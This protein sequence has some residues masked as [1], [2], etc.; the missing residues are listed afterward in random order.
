MEGLIDNICDLGLKIL[1]ISKSDSGGAGNAAYRLHKAMI[2]LG[3]DSKM[4]CLQKSRNGISSLVK[5]SDSILKKTLRSTRLPFNKY[6]K[7]NSLLKKRGGQYES[8]SFIESDYQVHKHQLIKEADV[9]NLHFINGFINYNSFFMKVQKPIIWTLH[10]MNP[11][12]GGFHYQEDLNRNQENLGDVE[13]HL[14][15]EKIA[16][17]KQCNELSIVSLNKWMF[18]LARN[19]EHFHDRPNLI[20]SNTLDF[21]TFNIYDKF[22]QRK[23]FGLPASKIIL[24]FVSFH[25]GNYR[26]GGDLLLQSM[27]NFNE[28]DVI[29]CKIG[30]PDK[31]LE[32]NDLIIDLG[33]FS[34][35][36][37]L[38]RLYSAADAVILPSREDNLPNVLLESLAC[39]TPVISTPVGGC[40]D[41]LEHG[42]NGLLT[43]DVSS[44]SLTETI[45][46]FIS[47]HES[48]DK[49]AIRAR[50]LETFSPEIIVKKYFEAYGKL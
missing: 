6:V 43:K 15:F 50:A 47:H 5:F 8:F 30:K 12:M 17:Y 9:I 29:F 34:N 3:V 2:D 26:K 16:I 33:Y 23:R 11:F 48:F 22:E 20:I 19:S 32:L 28:K 44:K 27:K 39:G 37:E 14:R 4:L 10:D 18:E 25:L 7:N 40:L 45:F 24:I 38:A 42:F 13:D 35:E 1:H 49:D 21:E 41:L 36:K 31:S 46:H